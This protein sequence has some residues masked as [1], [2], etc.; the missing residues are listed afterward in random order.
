LNYYFAE[1][2]FCY[3]IFF[4]HQLVRVMDS[5]S[6]QLDDCAIRDEVWERWHCK[7][8]WHVLSRFNDVMGQY[9]VCMEPPIMSLA[10]HVAIN[11]VSNRVYFPWTTRVLC[12]V[13]GLLETFY[14]YFARNQVSELERIQSLGDVAKAVNVLHKCGYVG[15]DLSPDNILLTLNLKHV[16]GASSAS[17]QHSFHFLC[18]HNFYLLIIVFIFNH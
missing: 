10:E 14:I 13:K 11:A 17:T 3:F 6:H 5:E 2:F 16:Y 1:L 9:Y 12:Q 4:F 15:M 18:I 8:V 7:N